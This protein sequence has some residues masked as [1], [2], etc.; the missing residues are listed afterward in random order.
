MEWRAPRSRSPFVSV[1]PTDM[2]AA[3]LQAANALY[4]RTR[5]AQVLSTLVTLM[6][7][8]TTDG[9]S[10]AQ[11]PQVPPARN[12]RGAPQLRSDLYLKSGIQASI[13]FPTPHTT[14]DR[15]VTPFTVI[16]A[17]VSSERP[18]ADAVIHVCDSSDGAACSYAY[19]SLAEFP[20][21]KDGPFQATWSPDPDRIPLEKVVQFIAWITVRDNN[22]QSVSSSPVPFQYLI[23]DK[24]S[25]RLLAPAAET[26]LIA[27][28]AVMMLGSYTPQSGNPAP[29]DH[30]EFLDGSTPI[31][32]LT[33]PNVT[34][35]GYAL[36]WKDPSLGAHEI[37]VR[38]VDAAGKT[39][40]SVP[41]SIYIIAPDGAID[42]SL[43]R[44][45]TGETF[46]VDAPI[47]LRATASSAGGSIDRVEFVDGTVIV[48]TLVEPPFET[49]WLR[50]SIGIHAISARAYDDLGFAAAS[51][52]AYVETADSP[53]R[54]QIVITSPRSGSVTKIGAPVMYQAQVDAPDAAISRVEFRAEGS[55]VATVA[56]PPFQFDWTPPSTG[57]HQASAIAFDTA[58]Y[59]GASQGVSFAVT[60]D[61]NPPGGGSS[62]GAAPTVDLVFPLAGTAFA[63]G[64]TINFRVNA[65]GG[66]SSL[67]RVDYLA[68]D[69]AIASASVP[70]WNA[71]WSGAPQGTYTMI[72][73]AL[74]YQNSSAISRPVNISVMPPEAGGTSIAV[75][76][77]P[78]GA[79]YYPGDELELRPAQMQVNGD[80]AH[81]DYY[82][83]GAFAGSVNRAPYGINWDAVEPGTHV[84]FAKIYDTT[85]NVAQS[86]PV[87]IEVKPFAVTIITPGAGTQMQSVS[88]FIEGTYAGPDNIG[89]TVNG[90]VAVVD[91][92]G[93]FFINDL[94]VP[95]GTSNLTAIATTTAGSR[96][97]SVVNVIG[98][99]EV[100]VTSGRV[101][102]SSDEG[103]GTLTMH[104][105]VTGLPNI[106][107]WRILDANGAVM[108][109]GSQTD[110]DLTTLQFSAPGLYRQTIEV[111]DKSNRVMLK[112][113]AAL[114]WNS[115]EFA[116]ARK[117]VV[118]QFLEALRREQKDKA[119]ATLT[120]GVAVQFAGVFDAL[121]GHW[122]EIMASLHETGI[123]D[124][125]V[126][127]FGAATTRD[128]GGQR[129]LYLIEGV[130]DSDGTW[131][132]DS[133]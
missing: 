107:H 123:T 67:M 13:E 54:P 75:A 11:S 34:P 10:L 93:R 55:L 24:R 21:G 17:T 39:M 109:Q 9:S 102:V 57:V 111:T 124:L 33:T 81:I 32:S 3:T 132:I 98:S 119:L 40:S 101:V 64:S 100:P 62:T 133:F 120:S 63:A 53:R 5:I 42:V 60:V 15:S 1:R 20:L 130:R 49:T 79:T 18:I 41:T 44:P 88:T 110:G 23:S 121:K 22:G 27:P 86:P 83:D 116:S 114:V 74:T 26:G 19:S 25:A 7:F 122:S 115:A 96:T 12:L 105:A 94:P 108:A 70:P 90:T 66:E 106:D 113:L 56:S 28:A 61:G 51:S 4:T 50:P 29:L 71:S 65:A 82:V 99:S 103:I 89:I 58:G 97:S 46:A 129:F 91:G 16:T 30:I 78:P 92:H 95:A 127:S 117:S 84:V 73:K 52:A 131:R 112:S 2:Q 14:I 45:R 35:P 85:G 37:S 128:R 77:P 76:S 31:G 8:A 36:L 48:A 69:V 87:E 47:P 43:D 80:I 59:S 125:G 38:A 104:V 6:L 126:E 68:N 118:S 72:A